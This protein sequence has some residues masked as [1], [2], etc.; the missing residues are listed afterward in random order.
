MQHNTIR[1]CCCSMTKKCDGYGR[2]MVAVYCCSRKVVGRLACA[3]HCKCSCATQTCRCRLQKQQE[4]GMK[5]PT[6]QAE[7]TLRCLA[8]WVATAR[9]ILT[10][11]H[12]C[13]K[14]AVPYYPFCVC[15]SVC[16]CVK[17]R[18]TSISRAA[19]NVPQL[20]VVAGSVTV[21][22]PPSELPE[23]LDTKCCHQQSS[24]ATRYLGMRFVCVC[25]IFCKCED[26]RVH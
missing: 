23:I 18:S 9:P 25:D 8:A 13:T 16:V 21:F 2:K 20:E 14:R 4:T 5:E 15:L 1:E 19:D 3:K 22:G 17:G 10:C 6:M 7:S 11:L 12:N 24:T 26:E